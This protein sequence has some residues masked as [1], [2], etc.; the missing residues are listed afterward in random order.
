MEE[1][2]EAE[3]LANTGAELTLNNGR[4]VTLDYDYGGLR[5]IEK[6]FGGVRALLEILQDPLGP[7][8]FD[9]VFYGVLFG[10]WKQ[11]MSE[12][13]LESLISSRDLEKHG[14]IVAGALIAS[15]LERLRRSWTRKR[16]KATASRP[17]SKS[18]QEPTTSPSLSAAS[19]PIA[20]G[21]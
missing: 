19:T 12:S 13:E 18:G 21:E 10:L 5:R 7:R 11:G 3:R 1:I 17:I 14:E 6:H 4:V 8:F 15:F 16:R 2:T 9:G 20:S